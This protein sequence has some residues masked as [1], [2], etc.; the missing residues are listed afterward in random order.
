[1]T[2]SSSGSSHVLQAILL[3][4]DGRTVGTSAATFD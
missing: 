4:A 1:M 2:W 3:G